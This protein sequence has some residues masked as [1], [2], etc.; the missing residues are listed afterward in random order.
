[1]GLFVLLI[2][3]KIQPQ[4]SIG[5]N[6]FVFTKGKV[7]Y[8]QP[9]KQYLVGTREPFDMRVMAYCCCMFIL[10]FLASLIEWSIEYVVNR[11]KKVK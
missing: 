7:M 6:L 10:Q 9:P 1:M 2:Y 5:F 3:V 11:L 8:V 4:G